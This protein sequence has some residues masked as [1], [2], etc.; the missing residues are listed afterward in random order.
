MD[1]SVYL[2]ADRLGVRI[3]LSEVVFKISSCCRLFF[4][5]KIKNKIMSGFTKLLDMILQG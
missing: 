3:K 5:K 2:S 4:L 1:T